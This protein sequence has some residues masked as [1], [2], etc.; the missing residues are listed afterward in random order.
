MPTGLGVGRADTLW[1]LDGSNQRITLLPLDSGAEPA[2]IPFPPGSS[3]M[4]GRI[5]PVADGAYGVLSMF[6]F[7]PGDDAGFPPRPLVRLGR[8]GVDADT[9]WV[10]PAPQFDRVEVT[11]GT[12]VMMMLAQQAFAPG[13][14]WDRFADGAFALAD[15]PEYDIR[16]VG[17]DGHERFRIRRE[18]AARLTTPE[19]EEY[20]RDRQREASVQGN[21]P[22]A[23]QMMEKRLEALT[24]AEVVARITGLAVD[25]RDRLWV[26]VS[27]TRPG[28]TDRIDVY[29]PAG[30]LLGEIRDPDFFPDLM[31]GDGL[32]ARITE[33]ELDVQQIVVYQLGENGAATR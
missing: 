33:D 7:Q 11:S 18:P 26:G 17:P 14:Y 8:D 20:E 12:R 31:Y 4:G 29:D 10:A 24:F 2:S 1:V 22:G 13:F 16:V 3:M 21:F 27:V 30:S 28:E 19:D 5:I 15:G 23:E 6:S 9:V 25:S 32:V